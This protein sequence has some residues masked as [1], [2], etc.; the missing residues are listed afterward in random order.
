MC[1]NTTDST[2]LYKKTKKTKKTKKIYRQHNPHYVKLRTKQEQNMILRE[3]QNSIVSS[4]RAQIRA[5]KRRVV[6]CAP[7]GAGKTAMFNYMVTRHLERGGKALI[8][9]HRLELMKQAAKAYG[10]K[11]EP[12][13]G[14]LTGN[15]HIGMVETISRRVHHLERFL[16]TRSMVIFDEA[17]LDPFTK[18]FPYISPDTIVIGATATPYRKASQTCLSEFY[19]AM[20]QEVDTW[21]LIEMGF[22][23]KAISYA[24]P[25]N[26]SGAKQSGTD[27]DTKE[28]YAKTELFRGVVDNYLKRVQGEK[29]LLFASN[30]ESSKEVCQ[31]FNERGITARHLDGGTNAKE[32]ERILDWF[33]STPDAV[34]CNC[35]V[36]TAGFDQPDV[37]VVILYRATTSLPLFL[38]MCGRG[39]RV[40]PSKKEFT[41]LDFGNNIARL[42]FWEQPRKWSLFKQPKRTKEKGA[43]AIKECPA[44]GALLLASLH[45]CN[46]CGYQF[47]VNELERKYAELQ[48][49]P[50]YDR[51]KLAILADLAGKI[52]MCKRK[53]VHPLF[54][55]RHLKSK[56]EMR[57]FQKEMGYK[58]GWLH[59]NKEIYEQLAD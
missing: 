18:I 54:I 56:E 49:L 12:I 20:V 25:I 2:L 57:F 14:D 3:Y 50:S 13:S 9:T 27:Y 28:I 5:G 7:T 22:L 58:K 1:R 38:Q 43:P 48:L 34:L 19:E 46:V 15:L 10:R 53:L 11:A 51:N 36:L 37:K 23:A 42:G 29:T 24:V 17:H 21:Q 41:I 8:V 59:Y 52:E 40:T 32:R 47:P 31:E 33:A 6:M 39:S 35:G 45:A 55:C 44:C 30:V 4:I 16:K 26:L